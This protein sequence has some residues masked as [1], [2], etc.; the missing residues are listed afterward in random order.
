MAADPAKHVAIVRAAVT[1]YALHRQ[2]PATCGARR[3]PH[4][5]RTPTSLTPIERSYLDS[6]NRGAGNGAAGPVM[7]GSADLPA[8]VTCFLATGCLLLAWWIAPAAG[9]S[10]EA[11][12]IPGIFAVAGGLG[13]I[14]GCLASEF[15]PPPFEP[16]GSVGRR[17]LALLWLLRPRSWMLAW[18][19]LIGLMFWFG[20]PHLRMY[21]AETSYDI[22]CT[23]FGL[24]G[25][26]KRAY[27]GSS[28]PLFQWL[29]LP[30][31]R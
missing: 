21:Y 26:T 10:G 29:P 19:L 30:A 23:Y 2:T 31:A 28:C 24:N 17:V 8:V 22:E 1:H 25:W 20:T 18:A 27:L 3:M 4:R 11:W 7:T 13:L 5:R 12:V 14:K 15:L 9:A 16:R 6:L